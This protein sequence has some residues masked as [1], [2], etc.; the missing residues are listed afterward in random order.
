MLLAQHIA[1]GHCAQLLELDIASNSLGDRGTE[2]LLDSVTH[3]KN[4]LLGVSIANNRVSE[5]CNETLAECIEGNV[6]IR[7]LVSYPST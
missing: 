3:A 7:K 6:R 2:A 5:R 4:R 1:S